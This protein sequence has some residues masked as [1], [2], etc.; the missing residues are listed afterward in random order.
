MSN[1]DVWSIAEMTT[2][3]MVASLPALRSLLKVTRLGRSNGSS[4]EKH[5]SFRSRSVYI[6]TPHALAGRS[7]NDTS[8]DLELINVPTNASKS[9]SE[10]ETVE[11]AE[12]Q[13]IIG[14]HQR[15]AYERKESDIKAFA[16]GKPVQHSEWI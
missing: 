1:V 3:I 13:P 10:V 6:S 8:S 2:A 4:N 9:K 16:Q 11:M 7:S 15:P 12:P 14:V 5:L